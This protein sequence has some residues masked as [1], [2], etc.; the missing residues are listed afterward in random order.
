MHLFEKKL[1]GQKIF[2]GKIIDLFLDKVELEDG[3]IANREVVNHNGGVCVV[4][5]TDDNKIIM[6]KQYR[7]P[8]GEVVLEIPAGKLDKD[9]DHFEAGKRELLEETGMK[10]SFYKF[11]GE[12]YPAPAYLNEI[13]YMYIA[14]DLIKLSQKLDEDEFLDIEYYY[15]DDLINMILSGEIKDAKTQTAILKT[16]L[17]I[18][19]NMV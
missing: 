3:N 11:I 18:D 8:M 17:L 14:K 6:V 2:S 1:D 5:I 16:K 19:N 10:A 4:P 12:L 9:E 7:Y 13:I 15:I